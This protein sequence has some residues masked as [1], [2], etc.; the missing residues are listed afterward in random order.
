M[1]LRRAG[2]D[3]TVK[4]AAKMAML[5]HITVY[6]LIFACEAAS[7]SVL[8]SSWL[9]VPDATSGSGLNL[10]LCLSTINEKRFSSSVL[11]RG[12]VP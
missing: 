2:S 4:T 9:L 10:V 1:N 7:N 8:F 3:L 12:L 11:I 5:M 6:C